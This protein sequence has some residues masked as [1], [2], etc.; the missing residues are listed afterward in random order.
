LKHFIHHTDSMT[1]SLTLPLGSPP[2][3]PGER[4]YKCPRCGKAFN[5][6]VVLQTHMVRHTGEKPHL[7]MFCPASFS[8]KGNLHSHVQRVHSEVRAPH[9]GKRVRARVASGDRLG[10]TWWRPLASRPNKTVASRLYNRVQ[11]FSHASRPIPAV[12]TFQLKWRIENRAYIWVVFRVIAQDF[13]NMVR[14][15]KATW[16][17]P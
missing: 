8:Q 4:P 11:E 3:H 6:K 13:F 9:G 16:I 14:Y 17:P 12:C 5:Q 2:P 15:G 7:C 10:V 1:C